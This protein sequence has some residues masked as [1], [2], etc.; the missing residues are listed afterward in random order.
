MR[1][2]ILLYSGKY[3][4]QDL[5]ACRYL[6]AHIPYTSSLLRS[7]PSRVPRKEFSFTVIP[8]LCFTQL[9]Y[10]SNEHE[11]FENIFTQHIT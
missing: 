9:Y 6:F 2:G 7:F 11:L 4:T 10:M 3:N 5:V 1:R 8:A